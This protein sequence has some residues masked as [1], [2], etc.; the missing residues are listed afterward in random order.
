MKCD[1]LD[2][3]PVRTAVDT[4]AAGSRSPFARMLLGLATA[5]VL[6]ATPGQVGAQDAAALVRQGVSVLELGNQEAML[7][8][9]AF[10]EEALRADSRN[11][12]AAWRLSEVSYYL[13]EAASGWDTNE[14]S[15][16]AKLLAYSKHGAQ[17]GR[18]AQQIN[19]DG[20]EGL[21][22]L[23]ANLALWGMSNGVLDSLAQV[24]HILKYT[25]RCIELDPE[26]NFER[27]G[28]YRIIGGVYTKLPGFPVS[29][30]DRGK[31]EEYLKRS[32][33][34]GGDYGINH[35]LLAEVYLATGD[36]AKAVKVL[37][38]NIA[39][40]EKRSRTYLDSRDLKRARTLL[41]TAR[42][43]L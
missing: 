1:V 33:V 28:C 21:F 27:G 4:T 40:L 42:A 14:G 3:K 39:R 8:A 35:N 41:E 37:E 18:L 31:A 29:V 13:W 30:G 7:Q 20:V 26:G 5:I 17:A 11:Y 24:P 10:Y 6:A 9:K 22:W 38:G 12:E 34:K 19:A 36:I 15:K 25:Q 32:L 23:S 2:R 43:R 16:Q